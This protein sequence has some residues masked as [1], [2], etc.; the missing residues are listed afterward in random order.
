MVEAE[1]YQSPLHAPSDDLEN[2]QSFVSTNTKCTEPQ[3]QVNFL[4]SENARIKEQQ[5]DLQRRH[6]EEI[7]HI[8]AELDQERRYCEEVEADNENLR[9]QIDS[10]RDR[11]GINDDAYYTDRL[12]RLNLATGAW[13]AKA[14]KERHRGGSALLSEK[15]QQV[16]IQALEQFD[17]GKS[18]TAL[19]RSSNLSINAIMK[20]VAAQIALVRQLI[21]LYLCESVFTPFC[22]GIPQDQ[23]RFISHILESI[24]ATTGSILTLQG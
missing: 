19:L 3:K 4:T 6:E 18:V 5:R 17:Q 21:W 20:N 14:A 7:M 23:S 16:L 15:E 2:E 1:T 22:F 13:A 11:G 12:K 9:N 24:F 8:R 10:M